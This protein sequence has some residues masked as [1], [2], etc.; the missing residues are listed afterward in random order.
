MKPEDDDTS[1]IDVIEPAESQEEAPP[2]EAAPESGEVTITLG[3]PEP[4]PEE[5]PEE[6]LRPAIKQ[7]RDAHKEQLRRNRELERKLKEAEAKAK[8][9]EPEP[10]IGAKP[11]LADAGFD[12]EEFEKRLLD[13]N[14]RKASHEVRQ[15]A[16]RDAEAKAQE[17]Y[18]AKLDTYRASIPALKVPDY[19]EAEA[20][21]RGMLSQAQ[22]SVLIKYAS[23][24]ATLIY[25]LHKAPEQAKKLAAIT[26]LIEFAIAVKDLEKQV[27]VM[28]KN[29]PPP[30]ERVIRGSGSVTASADKHLEKLREEAARTGDMTK[31]VRYK[32]ELAQA[33]QKRA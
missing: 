14:N 11:T 20:E 10:E 9:A 7:L 21:L 24:P 30:P 5:A 31:V 27:K 25:A 22:G 4:E 18:Q 32:R 2:E 3:D 12:E 28:P 33:V 26:D 23:A 1:E 15:Q 6:E 17:A 16:Q 29:V 8:Q 19:A 13:W